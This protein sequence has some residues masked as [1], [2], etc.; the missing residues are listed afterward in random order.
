MFLSIPFLLLKKTKK[1]MHNLFSNLTT[2]AAVTS[3][4]RVIE[5]NL[6]QLINDDNIPSP[7]PNNDSYIN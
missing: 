7:H 4:A 5:I 3:I 1:H 6:K 2:D